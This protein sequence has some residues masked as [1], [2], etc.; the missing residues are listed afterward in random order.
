MATI[1]VDTDGT[2]GDYASLALAIAAVDDAV[3]TEDTA[4]NAIIP[5]LLNLAGN[6]WSRL[7]RSTNA[8]TEINKTT[9]TQE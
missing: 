7:N 4:M 1:T 9:D 8:Y 2:S 5:M 3:L 6:F